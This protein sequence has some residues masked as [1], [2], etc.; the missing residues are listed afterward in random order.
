MTEPTNS[1]LVAALL[2][3]GPFA[4]NPDG[5]AMAA[6]SATAYKAGYLEGL[7]INLMHDV[8]GVRAEIEGRLATQKKMKGED[9]V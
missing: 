1:E 9:H 6:I 3:G 5:G 8:P 4:A 2:Q 7:L